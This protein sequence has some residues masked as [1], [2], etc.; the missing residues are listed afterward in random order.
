MIWRDM[1]LKTGDV[2]R[3]FSW[4]YF[5]RGEHF[6]PNTG[7]FTV[8]SDGIY[9]I[10]L[11]V[12]KRSGGDVQIEIVLEE[13]VHDSFDT[14]EC[15]TDGNFFGVDS[16]EVDGEAIITTILTVNTTNESNYNTLHEVLEEGNKLFLKVTE[17][18]EDEDFKFGN[19]SIFTCYK[20]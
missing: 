12:Y 15:N 5:N 3:D 19:F 2:I 13:K 14:S 17:A 11:T 9:C 7:E 20:I 16:S 18:D 10:C 8:P 4:V 1:K 6:D